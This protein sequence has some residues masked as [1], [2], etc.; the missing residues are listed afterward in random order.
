MTTAHRRMPSLEFPGLVNAHDRPFV[1]PHTRVRLRT[2]PL[3]DDH[4]FLLRD[5]GAGERVMDWTESSEASV[6]ALDWGKTMGQAAGTWSVKLKPKHEGL[7]LD[8]HAI[9]DGDWADITALRN[10]VP[11]PV[12]RGV[13]DS[14]RERKYSVR[15]ATGFEYTISGRDH[16]AF[17]EYPITWNSIWA[18]TLSETVAGLFTSRVKGRVGGR[19][20]ELFAALIQG[21]FA[22]GADTVGVPSGQWTVPE[23]IKDRLPLVTAPTGTDNILVGTTASQLID[24]LNVFTFNAAQDIEGLRGAYY[25]EPQLW[26]VGEQDLHAT[27]MQWVNPLLNEFWYDLLMPRAFMPPNGLNK[28]LSAQDDRFRQRV[29]GQEP[30]AEKE[31]FGT[32]AAFC[33]ERPFPTV[34]QGNDSMWFNLPT[35]RIPNWLLQVQELG[36]GGQERF[37]VF[38]LLAD[39]GL[40]P[41]Q[42]QAAFSRPRW[43]KE[44]IERRGLRAYS[45]TTRYFAQEKGGPEQW[46]EERDNWVSILRDWFA[47]NPYLRNGTINV[48]CLLPEIRIGQR[49]VVDPGAK[50]QEEQF[51]VE[52]VAGSWRAATQSTG[53]ASSQQFTVTRGFT[54]TDEELVSAVNRLPDIYREVF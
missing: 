10:G 6:I 35:W 47:P 2:Y 14:V 53:E 40:G 43:H 17:F 44:D 42:E 12:M 33:R 27:L 39:F 34:A 48:K 22:A 11:I 5:R 38:E 26:T 49:L 41:Q 50:N 23:S 18:R 25:N 52:G 15:G 45:Q 4:P 1:A 20:D 29:E 16:G 9:I 19:P 54:G 13:V 3:N 37:N 8:R 46:F 31:E 21:T 36:N 30:T 28:F 51:Y 7:R 24:I 32:L